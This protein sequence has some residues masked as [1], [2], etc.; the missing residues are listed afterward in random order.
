MISCPHDDWDS[1][2]TDEPNEQ[3][4]ALLHHYEQKHCTDKPQPVRDAL[5][6]CANALAGLKV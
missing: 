3:L 2:E 5:K 6:A 4:A 1:N